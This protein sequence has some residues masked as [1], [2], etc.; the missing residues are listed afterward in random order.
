LPYARNFVRLKMPTLEVILQSDDL[1]SDPE[2]R[3]AA[4]KTLKGFCATYLAHHLPL[5]PSD[6]FDE[7]AATLQ[8]FDIKRVEVIGFRGCAK[9]PQHRLPLS[10][11]PPLSTQT[12]TP[13]SSCWPTRA[14]T[15]SAAFR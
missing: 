11:G 9:A 5:V 1:V 2:L 7:M 6:F 14:A 12:F 13:S 10:Y 3:R 4:A 8:D 15:R